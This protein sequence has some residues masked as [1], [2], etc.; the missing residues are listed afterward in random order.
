MPACGRNDIGSWLVD[1]IDDVIYFDP[2]AVPF[3]FRLAINAF[4]LEVC[5][6]RH[7]VLRVVEQV[8]TI[9][10]GCARQSLLLVSTAVERDQ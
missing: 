10:I 4:D 8:V 3:V 1:C 9:L 5:V 2:V 6:V 7:A